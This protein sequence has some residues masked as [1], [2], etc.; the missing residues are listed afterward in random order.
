MSVRPREVLDRRP[1]Q[2]AAL[3]VEAAAVAGA[4]EALLD[5]VPADDAAEV[6]ADGSAFAHGA[7]LVLEDRVFREA[8]ADDRAGAGREVIDALDVAR[9]DE[10]AVLRDGV[11]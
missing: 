1:H 11:R 3:G 8:L 10:V 9:R 6:I 2:H 4:I 5:A 7:V